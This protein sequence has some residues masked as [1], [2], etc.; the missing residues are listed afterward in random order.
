M[1]KDAGVSG[2]V[3]IR[4]LINE[5]G[6]VANVE[7][8]RGVSGGKALDNEAVRVIESIPKMKP[9]KQRGKP[10]RVQYT[11]PVKFNLK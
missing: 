10:V 6:E 3:Y 8:L 2:T 7:V 1:A 11:V 9:G 4:Y 5:K